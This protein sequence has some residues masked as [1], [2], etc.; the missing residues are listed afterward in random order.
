ME[1]NL[2]LIVM[3]NCKEFGTKVMEHIQKKLNIDENLIVPISQVRFSN[4]EGKVNID[5]SVRNKDIY[6]ISDVGNYDC[7]YKMFGF[8]NHMGPDEHYQ[9]IKRVL[10]AIR[11]HAKEV[12]LI[13]PL[14]Y[15]SR[16]HRKNGRESLD[17]ALALQELHNLGINN[18]ITFDVHDPDL[19][20]AVPMADLVNLYPT[21]MILNDLQNNEQL[22]ENLVIVSPDTG[23]F[24]RA[25]YYADALNTSDFKTNVAIFHKRRDLTRIVDGKNPI[26]SH[27]YIGP[28]LTNKTAIVTDDLIASGGSMLDVVRELKKRGSK[29]NYL[30][31]T[32]PLFTSG[33]DEFDQAYS[34]GL[35]EKI[36]STN[37]TYL[38]Q[39]L[40]NREW[41]FASDCSHYLA[42]VITTLHQKEE[43]TPI[44]RESKQ[45]V[46]D[47]KN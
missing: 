8:E 30:V 26:I 29:K 45:L 24:G 22:D 7:T 23:A 18:F 11:N 37:L 27:E 28:E 4:G 1:N 43:L 3:D 15:E 36:Y 9:D 46:K 16:Q 13:M 5:S 2:K 10:C 12:T 32:F 39:E 38:P 31:A 19:Q 34:E 42:E 44:L 17:C 35:F 25:R 40:K 20:N 14:L 47:R 33:L 21:A 41:F 6:I